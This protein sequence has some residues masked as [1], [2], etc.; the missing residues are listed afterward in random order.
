MVQINRRRALQCAASSAAALIYPRMACAAED[1]PAK[2]LRIIVS[3]PPGGPADA[4]CRMVAQQMEPRLK[5]PVVVDNR[6]GATG[7]VALQAA[8]AAPADGHTLVHIHPGV[9]SGQIL[10]KRFDMAAGLSPISLAGDFQ[11][12]LVVS[13]AGAIHSMGDFKAAAARQGGGLTYGTL[14]I[15]SYEH[16]LIESL[17]SAMGIRTLH[18]PYKGGAEMVQALLGGQ[19]DF[20]YLITQL[21]QPY[22]SKGQI[23]ALAMLSDERNKLLTGVPTFSELGIPVKAMGYWMGLCAASGTPDHITEKLH[24]VIVECLKTPAIRH[25]FEQGGALPRYSES[26]AAFRKQIAED[27]SFLQGVI[28]THNIKLN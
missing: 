12:A 22:V 6:P 28:T 23:R 24:G 7:L 10:M 27:Q 1:W 15:G 17:C 9:I 21:A 16:L 8:A 5:Q 18:V 14:G 2:A 3:V 25:W 20:A 19:I 26:R 4:V 13:G 11:L